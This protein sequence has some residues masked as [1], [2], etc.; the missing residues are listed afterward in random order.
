MQ[1]VDEAEL[2]DHRQRST[3]PQLDR[4]GSDPDRPGRRRGER[5]DNSRGRAGDAGVE[6][7]LG[8]PVPGVAEPFG[9]LG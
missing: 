9:L 3:V 8:K 4:T 6:V 5:E 7:V 2:L 1:G